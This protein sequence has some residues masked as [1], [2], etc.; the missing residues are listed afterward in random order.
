MGTYERTCFRDVGLLFGK[1]RDVARFLGINKFKLSVKHSETRSHVSC[2]VLNHCLGV[3][4][5]DQ[6]KSHAFGHGILTSIQQGVALHPL[7]ARWCSPVIFVGLQT[8]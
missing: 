7:Y 8:P 1:I 5:F 3:R 4:N 6:C 2:L